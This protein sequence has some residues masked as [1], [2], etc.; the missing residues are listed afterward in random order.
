MLFR[1]TPC[2]VRIAQD[3]LQ[4]VSRY[5]L[6]R[7]PLEV[8]AQLPG[9]DKECVQRLL[10]YGVPFAGVSEHRADEVH[11]VLDEGS[12]RRVLLRCDAVLW[13]LEGGFLRLGEALWKVG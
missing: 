10:L 8:M 4:R 11:G 12:A 1:S 5:Y 13:S 3:L 6:D 9:G 2:S 7:M